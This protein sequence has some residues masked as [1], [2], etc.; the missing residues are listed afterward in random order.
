MIGETGRKK[1]KEIKKGRGERARR[2]PNRN[3]DVKIRKD[4]GQEAERENLKDTER[5]YLF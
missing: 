1:I 2:G 5:V 4:Q 3:K